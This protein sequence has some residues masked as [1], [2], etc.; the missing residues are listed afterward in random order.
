MD[1]LSF[2]SQGASSLIIE[3]GVLMCLFG[4]LNV[5]SV[6]R[7]LGDYLGSDISSTSL[8]EPFS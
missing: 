4:V 1:D 5:L 8:Y 3:T 6:V 2:G 7:N